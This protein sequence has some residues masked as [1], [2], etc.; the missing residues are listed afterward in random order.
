VG[1]AVSHFLIVLEDLYVECGLGLKIANVPYRLG[2]V[3]ELVRKGSEGGV[4]EGPESNINHL[5]QTH[6]KWVA[7]DTNG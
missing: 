6:T 5:S 3:G 1:L 4:I 7:S 2:K